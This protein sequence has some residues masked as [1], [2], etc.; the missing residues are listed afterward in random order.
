[1]SS[2][3]E[4]IT[5]IEQAVTR[6]LEEVPALKPLK[7]VAALE[8]RGRGDVQQFRIEL[9]GPKVTKDIAA[10]AKVR[11]EMPRAFFNEMAKDARVPDWRE[12]FSYGQAKATGVSQYLRLIEQVVDRHEER[13][14]ARRARH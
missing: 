12:A 1:M 8:L 13:L 14:R 6:F 11:I 9:P 7:L 3:A 4:A 10:D 5:L 2:S